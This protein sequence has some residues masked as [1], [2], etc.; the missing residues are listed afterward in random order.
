MTRRTVFVE[1]ARY[2]ATVAGPGVREALRVTGARS[3]AHPTRRHRTGVFQIHHQDINDVLAALE[4]AGQLVEI[5][6]R[7]RQPVPYGGLL[8]GVA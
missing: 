7:D 4:E 3:M 2:S 8:G 5:V 1:L 6:G